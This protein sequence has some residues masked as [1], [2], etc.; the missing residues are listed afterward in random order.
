MLECLG[1]RWMIVASLCGIVAA[2]D[3]DGPDSGFIMPGVVQPSE[4]EGTATV[5]PRKNDRP[6]ARP[7]VD[8]AGVTEDAGELSDAGDG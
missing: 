4:D 8:D 1:M 6:V 3:D 5:P 7:V 2:C